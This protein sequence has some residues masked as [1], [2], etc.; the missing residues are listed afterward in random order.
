[1]EKR[2]LLEINNWVGKGTVLYYESNHD[3]KR[4]NIFMKFKI[5]FWTNFY[6]EKNINFINI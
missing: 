3:K 6:L 4:T 1:M 2:K 5:I